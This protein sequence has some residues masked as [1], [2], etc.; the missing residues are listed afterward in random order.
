L[1]SGGLEAA[2]AGYERKAKA[3]GSCS[4]DAVGHVGN[5]VAGDLRERVG[6]ARIHRSDEQSGVWVS[7]S[8]TKPLQSVNGKPTSFYQV[9]RFHE[10]YRRYMHVA[11]IADSIF[12]RCPGNR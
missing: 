8:R 6:Y 1:D 4:D 10:G 12:N 7:E 5:N 2:V 11:S 3:E 9:N